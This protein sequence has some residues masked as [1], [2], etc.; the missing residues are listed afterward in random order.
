MNQV[1]AFGAFVLGVTGVVLFIV[2]VFT[3]NPTAVLI[4]WLLILAFIVT[5]WHAGINDYK[6]RNKK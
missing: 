4:A 1:F 6:E 5:A 3:E 2:G